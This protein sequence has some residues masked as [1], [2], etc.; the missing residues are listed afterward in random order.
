MW[1]RHVDILPATW[2]IVSK[3]RTSQNSWCREACLSDPAVLTLTA[4][5]ERLVGVPSSHFEPYQAT[6]CRYVVISYVAR[7]VVSVRAAVVVSAVQAP[8]SVF[9]RCGHGRLIRRNARARP[10]RITPPRERR[11]VQGT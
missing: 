6:P 11:C 9:E 4:R 1:P 2:Q 10:L 3:K 7:P 8:R 5:I